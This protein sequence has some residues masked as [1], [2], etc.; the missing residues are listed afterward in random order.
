MKR[1]TALAF[2]LFLLVLCTG[3]SAGLSAVDELMRPP[4][5][6]GENSGIQEAFERATQNK[7][8]QIQTPMAGQYRSAYVLFDFDGDGVQEAV[9]FYHDT[10][11]DT[12]AYMHILD[13]DGAQWQSAADIRGEGSEVYEIAFCDMN[14]DGMQELVVCWSLYESDG[15]RVMTV[16]SPFVS[17]ESALSVRRIAQEPVSQVLTADLNSDGRDELFTVR[18]TTEYASNRTLCRLLALDDEFGVYTLDS[19]ELVP[20]LSVFSLCVSASGEGAPSVFADCVRNE[21]MAVT[22]VVYW[23]AA[24]HCLRAPLTDDNRTAQP[25]TARVSDLPCLDVDADGVPEIP[26]QQYYSNAVIASGE[27]RQP[28]P[29][30][31]WSDLE[32][33]VL[34]EKMSALFF[35]NASCALRISAQELQE[36]T[37]IY[38]VTAH[39]CAFYQQNKDGTRG[40]LLFTLSVLPAADWDSSESSGALLLAEDGTRTY[41]CEL[42]PKGEAAG[43]TSD[44]L[45]ERFALIREKERVQA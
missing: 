23:D 17:E 27:D 34:Q 35:P 11:D 25:K 9:T 32:G 41:I 31:I 4:R 18:I 6:S 13:F 5:L 39:S 16:Y 29:L 26:T 28:L 45:S 36:M 42:T 20:A 44:T 37:V 7:N 2:L 24:A 15:G 40:E 30:T 22:E 1:K 33:N 19:I 43:F 8:V 14:A 10:R 21:N 3:C 12:T 38:D